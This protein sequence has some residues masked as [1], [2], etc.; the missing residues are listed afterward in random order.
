M[1]QASHTLRNECRDFVEWHRGRSPYVLWALDVDLPAVRQRLA[2]A[3]AHLD[4]LLLAGYRRQ[5]HVTLDLCGFPAAVPQAGDEF[6]PV[7]LAAHCQAQAASFPA[8]FMIEVG[9]LESFTSAPYLSVNDPQQGIAALRAVIA[10]NG[11][12]RSKNDY[13]PHVTVGLY[14]D[15][16]PAAGVRAR[17]AAFPPA[18]TVVCR[19]DKLALLAYQPQE[20]GGP[21]QRLGEF[22]LQA[23]EFCWSNVAGPCL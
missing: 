7:E 3:A 17:L 14:A 20:I 18:P 15:A 4:G 6:S 9:G 10:V 13:V 19:I 21:L 12:N 2:A 22:C 8:P 23:R 11:R 5:A 16:W 1:Q